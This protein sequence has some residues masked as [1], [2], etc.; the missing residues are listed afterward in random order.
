MLEDI[1]SLLSAS[2]INKEFFGKY[3]NISYVFQLIQFNYNTH[4]RDAVI[5]ILK[6]ITEDIFFEQ[7][8]DTPHYIIP[9]I[10]D[11]CPQPAYLRRSFLHKEFQ[12]GALKHVYS[13]NYGFGVFRIY[14]DIDFAYKSNRSDTEIISVSKD[15]VFLL[16]KKGDKIDDCQT[17]RIFYLNAK[18]LPN[19]ESL[20]IRKFII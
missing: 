17:N 3:W 13:D 20:H 6:E 14:S 5:K 12:T 10:L 19:N 9:K 1:T 4:F 2:L 8:I 16:F 11:Q 7:G 18:G 15:T